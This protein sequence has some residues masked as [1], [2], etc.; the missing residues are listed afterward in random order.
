MGWTPLGLWG[1]VL[2]AIDTT[3]KAAVRLISDTA[4]LDVHLWPGSAVNRNS[5]AAVHVDGDAVTVRAGDSRHIKP[6]WD[7]PKSVVER[8]LAEVLHRLGGGQ[9][10]ECVTAAYR[11]RGD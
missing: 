6:K 2:G 5:V 8:I 4:R 9:P 3:R 7:G 1:A 10:S 11:R